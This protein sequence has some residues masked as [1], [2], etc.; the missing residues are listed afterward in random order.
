M[1]LRRT[2]ALLLVVLLGCSGPQRFIRLETGEG[3]ALLHLP[4]TAE[5]QPVVVGREEFQ[6]SLQQLA[7]EVR[8]IGSPRATVWRMFQL[9]ALS[10]DYLYLLQERKIVPLGSGTPLEGTL[11]REEEQLTRDYTGWCGRAYRAEGDCLGGALVGGRYLDVQGRYML[12][13]A[14]SRS[15]VLDEMREALGDMVSVQAI[16]SA[17][18]WTVGTLLVLLTLPEPITKGLAAV[19]ATVLVLWVGVDTLYNLTTGWLRLTQEAKEATTF[20]ELREAGERFGKVLGRDAARAFAMLAVAAIGQTAHGFAAKMQTLPGSAQV[21]MQA[22][23]QGNIWLPA[24]ASVQE[25]A[26]TAEGLSVVLPPGAVA[27][28]ARVGARKHPGASHRHHR[29]RCLHR[30]RRP[31]EPQVPGHLRPSWDEAERPGE[32]DAPQRAQGAAP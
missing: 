24:V 25:V 30:A 23:A 3:Q 15:P 16:F 21:A 4:R 13:L 18:L 22:E 26:V 5:V 9:D 14:L 10:G 28:A 20:G 31:V 32:Q 8:L 17:A 29:Q 12:A 6:D 11:T 7:R 27:M 19:L 2:A 1:M